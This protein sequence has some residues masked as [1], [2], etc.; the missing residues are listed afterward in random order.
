LMLHALVL[1]GHGPAAGLA[2]VAVWGIVVESDR[3]AP[4]RVPVVVGIFVATFLAAVLRREVVL[5]TLAVAAVLV[6]RA[7]RDRRVSPV[8]LGATPAVAAAVAF[9]SDRVAVRQIFGHQR[10]LPTS[11]SDQDYLFSRLDSFASLFQPGY[12]DASTLALALAVVAAAVTV[13]A[14][15]RFVIVGNPRELLAGTTLAAAVLVGRLLLAPPDMVPG[16]VAAFPIGVAGLILATRGIRGAPLPSELGASLA[17]FVALVV[18]T[19]YSTSGAWEWGSRYLA[20]GF[21]LALPIAAVGLLRT[22]DLV[23]PGRLRASLVS[24]ATAVAVLPLVMGLLAQRD[25]RINNEANVTAAH[26]LATATGTDL[27]VSTN[28]AVPRTDTSQI[29]GAVRWLWAW[30]N[31]LA[32]LLGRLEDAGVDEVAF[33]SREPVIAAE[34]LSPLGWEIEDLRAQRANPGTQYLGLLRQ[35]D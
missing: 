14:A 16:I 34:Y 8:L 3:R 4:P 31:E 15:T 32:P 22:W 17:V 9:V 23:P 21:V 1:R 12:E 19:Q 35:V 13:A 25:A 28:P 24:T 11:G 26:E 2:A 20:V 5:L 29:D 7:I 30:P 6:T 33:S 18:L 27:V 10:S